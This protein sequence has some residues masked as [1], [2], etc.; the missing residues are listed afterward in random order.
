MGATLLLVGDACRSGLVFALSHSLGAE[1]AGRAFT[2]LCH[3]PARAHPAVCSSE[4]S[5]GREKASRPTTSIP[6]YSSSCVTL[7]D[8]ISPSPYAQLLKRDFPEPWHSPHCAF[9]RARIQRQNIKAPSN[10]CTDCSAIDGLVKLGA[11]GSAPWQRAS[12]T[13]IANPRTHY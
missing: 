10:A 6:T 3:A 11:I 9:N 7:L 13:D 1:Q 12:Y 2:G 5:A 4:K 8:S